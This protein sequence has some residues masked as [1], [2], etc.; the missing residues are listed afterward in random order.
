M[1]ETLKKINFLITKRQRKGL[2]ILTLLLFIGMVLEVL[3]LGILIPALSILLEPELVEKTPILSVLRSNLSEISDQSFLIFFLILIVF[4]YLIKT[5]FLVFLTY[6]QNRFLYNITAYLSHNLFKNYMTQQYSFHL[7]NNI[8]ELNKNLQLEISYFNNYILNLITIFIEAG[9]ILA[10]LST[11]IYIEPFG[12]LSIGFFYGFLSI[13]FLRLTKKKL[14]EWGG[15]RVELDKSI[16]KIIIESLGGIKDILILG[17]G[18]F[19]S[20]QFSSKTYLQSRVSSNQGTVSTIP[21]FYLELI[22]IVG[23]VSFII[24]MVFKGEDSTKLVTVLGVFVAATFR[25]IPS[26]N[27]ILAAV[28]LLKFYQPSINI[29]YNENKKYNN[30]KSQNRSKYKFKSKIKFEQVDF[31]F[32]NHKNILS[33]VDL[34]INIG[35]T[36]GIIG[37]SG[38]G[39]STLIDLLIGLHNPTS[40]NI[41]IDDDYNLHSTQSW[42]NNLGYVSQSIFLLDES[43]KNNIAFGVE[44]NNINKSRINELIKKV[45]LED[46]INTLSDGI[47][48]KVG[49]RGVQL[50]GG[51][52]QRI[53]LARS[54]YHDPDVLVL[55]E[56]TSALDSKTEE[57]VMNSINKLV[58]EK[59]IIIIAHRLSTLENCDKIFE[60]KNKQLYLI[61]NIK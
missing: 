47:E 20:D 5:L 44:Q 52:R 33:K 43:I 50:S 61:E 37:E 34:E 16:S 25:M 32:N 53:G 9:F 11:L 17:K 29:I 1:I 36:I 15:L 6:K 7:K 24:L 14:K 60:V 26:L 48:T 13:I 3:G 21:R 41:I 40:G 38:S 2:V 45:Q 56:A 46:F 42:R 27:R 23:L 58:G 10:V 35:D 49:E 31:G 28:Q 51:Q 59:T 55:D 12:A 22:S 19:Y 30:S 57:S 4:V 54:L 18:T 39:K 8:S